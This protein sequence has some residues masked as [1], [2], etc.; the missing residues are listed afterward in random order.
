[1]TPRDGISVVIPVLDDRAGLA[2]TL[3]ALAEQHRL[4]DEVIVVDGGSRDGSDE[5]ARGWL[6]GRLTLRLLC[7]PGSSIG[8]ARNAGVRAARHSWVA[9]TDA[10]CV[11]VPGWL[12]AIDAHRRD[13]DFVAGIVLLAADNA[14]QRVVAVTHYPAADELE[15]PPRWVAISHRLFGRG[16]CSDRVGGGSMAFSVAA[17]RAAGEMPEGHH[18]GEDRGF[19]LAVAAAGLRVVR[20]PDAAV[21]W[22]PPATWRTNVRQF[23]RYARGDVRLRGRGRHAARAA[24]WALAPVAFLRGGAKTRAVCALCG[25]SYLALPIRRARAV[26]LPVA[27]WCWRMPLAVAVKDLAQVGGALA[28]LLDARRDARAL[29]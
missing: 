6:D 2:Q 14:L 5:L 21:R 4:P 23:H 19:V 18:A 25:L 27:E 10:T 15:H 28:G 9:C 1:M 8:A 17:W 11:P 20:A 16:H 13:A 24:A 7:T 22:P 3:A 26:G 29:R 12:A